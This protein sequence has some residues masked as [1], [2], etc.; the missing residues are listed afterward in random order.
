MIDLVSELRLAACSLARRP[1][2]SLAAALTLALGLGANFTLFALVGGVLLRP[3][4]LP[5]PERLVRLF[6]AYPQRSEQFGAASRLDAEDWA[7][8]P[9]VQ[10]LGLYSTFPQSLIL[11]TG[12]EPRG[13]TTAYVS[14]SFFPTLGIKPE[15][16]RILTPADEAGDALTIVVSHGF[17]ERELGADPAA[18]GR[19]LTLSGKP[20]VVAGVLPASFRFPNREVEVWAPLALIPPD[21]IPRLRFVR[22]LSVVA[23]LAPGATVADV[24][25]QTSAIAARLREDYPEGRAEAEAVHAVP[26]REQLVGEVR[27]VLIALLA[28]V[29]LVLLVACANVANLLL[30]RGLSRRRSLAVQSALGGSRGRLARSLLL[31]SLLIG[32]GGGV[33]GLLA[34]AWG[35]DGLHLLPDSVLPRS[36]EVQIDASVLGFAVVASLATGVLL[37]LA[38]ALRLTRPRELAGLPG[39][40]SLLGGARAQ[41]GLRRTLVVAEVALTLAL[42][43]GSGLLLKSLWRLISVD[44][45]FSPHH[46]LAVSLTAPT[47]RYP[48]SG[49]IASHYSALLGR[50]AS[51]PAVESVGSIKQL[52]LREDG[53]RMGFTLQPPSAGGTEAINARLLQVSP[54]LF[55]TLGVPLLAGRQLAAS[56]DG[57]S[58]PVVLVNE[59]LAR[60]HFAGLSAVGQRLY[61]GERSAEVVG[62]VGDIRHSGLAEEAP[63]MVYI[64]QAQNQRRIFTFVLRTAGEPLSLASAV[65]QAIHEVDPQQP[66]TRIESLEGVIADTVSSR[67]LFGTLFAAFALLATVLAA[68]GVYAMVAFGVVQRTREIG[69]RM[70]IGARR[71][72][73]L[74]QLLREGLGPVTLGCVLGLGLALLAGRWLQG[75]LFEVS[76]LD[77]AVL[78]VVPLLLFAVAL[79]ACWFPARRA[80]ALDP[81]V[82]LRHEG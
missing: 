31:E 52:T 30:A 78:A 42:L 56:D 23:R 51:V 76:P 37:G 62:V 57:R 68:V 10:S 65:R 40:G 79:V 34:A 3:L 28:A 2:L 64:P 61:L 50:L 20:F 22:W 41:K 29:V 49:E 59:A 55:A 46:I 60:R 81:V 35:V 67:R 47:Y 63:A 17:W 1:G 25:Q 39:E 72:L 73:V 36:A 7:K 15:R 82:A 13:A 5:E 71:R 21:D 18:V 77:P 80:A 11:A 66:I 70:A 44:P 19:S 48:E 53:E 14:G 12:A 58:V 54:D 33:L 16:G 74:A 45:G 38:P 32:L 4:P 6:Q 9:G 69:L 26:L 8:A 24:Q 43:V 75:L 27:P